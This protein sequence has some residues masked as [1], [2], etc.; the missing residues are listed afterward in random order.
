[1]CSAR[2][3]DRPRGAVVQVEL[4]VLRQDSHQRDR[5]LELLGKHDEI[6]ANSGKAA[7]RRAILAMR[8]LFN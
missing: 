7:A 1:M 3:E 2:I 4:D 8:T 5:A 6:A